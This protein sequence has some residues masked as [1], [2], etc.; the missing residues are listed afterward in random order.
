[1]YWGTSRVCYK[2][3]KFPEPMCNCT[4]MEE[5]SENIC[6]EICQNKVWGFWIEGVALPSIAVFG[7][8]GRLVGIISRL[9]GIMER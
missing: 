8:I 5:T 3:D 4:V 2:A 9:A 7:I 1:M 6:D